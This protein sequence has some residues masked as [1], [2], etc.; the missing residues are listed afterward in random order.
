MMWKYE[1]KTWNRWFAWYP[2]TVP[3]GLS[4]RWVWMEWVERKEVFTG[5]DFDHYH[6]RINATANQ[7]GAQSD[8][9]SCC[10]S[11]FINKQ[12]G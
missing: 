9:A 2:V 12:K 6:R 3:V 7:Q 4:I 1:K 8:L 5:M 11:E 10:A